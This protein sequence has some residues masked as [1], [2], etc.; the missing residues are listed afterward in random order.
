MSGDVH[1]G[2]MDD[3]RL[4]R[5]YRVLRHRRGWRQA[6]VGAKAGVSQDLVSLV[7]RGRIENVSV[8]SL[9]A[10]ARALDAELRIELWFRAGELD[11]LVDE[12][13]AALVGAVAQRLDFGGV[14]LNGTNN[15]RPP[16]VPF[17]GVGLAGAGRE[18][19][20][21]TIE[22]MTRTRFL[23]IRGLRP[24]GTPLEGAP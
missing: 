20:G 5:R 10:V 6:D 2:S 24:A 13:H 22:E 1:D 11:R 16:V 17:G 14:V 12:G 19:D 3:G 15:Y 23:A 9:R 21:Y 4:G 7:E 18:G 8:R